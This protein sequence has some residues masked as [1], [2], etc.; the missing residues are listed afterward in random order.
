MHKYLPPI[1]RALAF[2][3]LG[4][5][6][7]KLNEE[8]MEIQHELQFYPRIQPSREYMQTTDVER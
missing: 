3:G 5:S 1:L 2:L 6:I 7:Y 8:V 4:Y